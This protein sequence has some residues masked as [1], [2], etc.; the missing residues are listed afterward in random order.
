M[1]HAD[2]APVDFVLCFGTPPIGVDVPRFGLWRFVVDG[3]LPFG[4]RA[5]T[6]GASSV[7]AA[8]HAEDG[9]ARVELQHGWLPLSLDYTSSAQRLHAVMAGWP[10]RAVADIESGAWPTLARIDAPVEARSRPTDWDLLRTWCALPGRR[11]KHWWRE[12]ARY[13]TWN[14]S[15][16]TLGAPLTDIQQL[17]PTGQSVRWLPPRPPL[18]YVADPFPYRHQGRD[19]LLVEEY[20][21][22]KGVL[23]R[24]SRVDPESDSP[25]GVP[26][27]VR[28][29]HLSYPFTFQD[30]AD[31]LC[32]PEMHQEDGCIVYRLRDDGSW[33]PLHHIL[34]GRRIV[35]PTFFRH[36]GRWW[37][38]CTEYR[39]KSGNLTLHGYHSDALAGPWTP[40][41]LDPLK[42]DLASA[43]PAGRPFTIG[44]RLYRPA[45]DCRETYG[46]AIHIMEV[47]A[48]SPD[49]FREALA[50]RLEPDRHSPY[51]HGRHHLVVD[52]T[53]VYSDGK[54]CRVDHGLWWKTWRADPRGRAASRVRR[55][56][57]PTNTPGQDGV[58]LP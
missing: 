36:D 45:Q 46:G 40:H 54:R 44:P 57:A 48:L 52:G 41:A 29:S 56:T 42:S 49:T 7:H 4:W 16:T 2:R 19:W 5:A 22:P 37:L 55:R 13:D 17:A 18:C 43:R 35:D 24:I 33:A 26:V 28:E 20:G 9:H 47:H 27:I 3:G 31:V 6:S 32:S 12:A 25:D 51:P 14:V 30:G 8:L 21:H 10:A 39:E 1:R 53:T 50:L 15:V 58:E 11:L 34:R 23:G 38:L